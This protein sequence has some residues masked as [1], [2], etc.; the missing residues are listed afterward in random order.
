MVHSIFIRFSEKEGQQ[1]AVG[2]T[3]TYVTLAVCLLRHNLK[4]SAS[5]YFPRIYLEMS[6]FLAVDTVLISIQS[7]NQSLV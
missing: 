1:A 7:M 3:Q 2:Q 5:S 4:G 6:G